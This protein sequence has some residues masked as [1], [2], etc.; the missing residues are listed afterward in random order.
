MTT[1]VVVA[2]VVVALV[3]FARGR[4][5][6]PSHEPSAAASWARLVA[7]CHGDEDKAERL[8]D[9]EQRRSVMSR[10]RAITIAIA[11]LL[12]ARNR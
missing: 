4:A 8:A 10:Q 11:R 12:D 9:F 2:L 3:L 7:L 5:T 6:S 1:L